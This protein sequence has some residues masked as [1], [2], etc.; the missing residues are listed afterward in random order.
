MSSPVFEVDNPTV[1][2]GAVP[3]LTSLEL[4]CLK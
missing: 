4:D 2:R 3:V 1:T